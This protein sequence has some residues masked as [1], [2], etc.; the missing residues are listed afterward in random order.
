M[1]WADNS[2]AILSKGITPVQLA[3]LVVGRGFVC[4]GEARS[5]VA[6]ADNSGMRFC[7]PVVL[8]EAVQGFATQGLARKGK[9]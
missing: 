4:H 6:R 9:G 5:G 2:G 8:D 7:M 3:P 1:V